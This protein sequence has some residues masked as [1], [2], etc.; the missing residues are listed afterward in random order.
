[1]NCPSTRDAVPSQLLSFIA[2]ISLR[3]VAIPQ[4]LAKRRHRF[5]P[6]SRIF[7]A[8][9]AYRHALLVTASKRAASVATKPAT[10]VTSE[11]AS[12]IALSS[13]ASVAERST[14]FQ[15]TETDIKDNRDDSTLK[16]SRYSIRAAQPHELYTAADIRCEA[17]YCSPQTA[18]YHPIRRRE[19]YMAMR[20]RID[21]GT[22][23]LVVVDNKPPQVWRA[24]ANYDGLVVGT[25]D[26]TLHASHS[27]ARKFF[28]E[29][30]FHEGDASVH[31]Y[32]SSMAVR[33]AWQGHG[34]AQLL[35]SYIKKCL[36][37]S[38]ISNALL[39][40]DPDNDVAAHVYRKAGFQDVVDLNGTPSW[41]FALAKPECILMHMHLC[42]R[43]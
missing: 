29:A 30:P 20:S 42:R 7:D 28:D 3:D 41:I 35:M 36:P 19:I 32:I 34:L 27:G 9:P 25:V 39:H 33:Q 43:V 16:L 6:Q 10:T 13:S 15:T 24:F 8:L 18:P 4:S 12:N 14:T 21:A 11:R 26:V 2:P 5:C 40:V 31:A 17:F 22:R 1:M 38:G 23:C 37:C